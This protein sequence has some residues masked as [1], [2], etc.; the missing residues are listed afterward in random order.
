MIGSDDSEGSSSINVEL[1]N[2]GTG[3]YLN[4]SLDIVDKNYNGDSP[5][6]CNL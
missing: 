4:L 2:S 5:G 3:F 6:A 1:S